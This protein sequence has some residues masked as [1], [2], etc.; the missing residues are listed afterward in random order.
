MLLQGKGHTTIENSIAEI[1]ETKKCLML[2]QNIVFKC[3]KSGYWFFI[4]SSKGIKL[5]VSRIFSRPEL[6]MRILAVIQLQARDA[7]ISYSERI[8]RHNIAAA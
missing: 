6:M 7:C 3:N 8:L 5:A 4:L 2:S 1:N